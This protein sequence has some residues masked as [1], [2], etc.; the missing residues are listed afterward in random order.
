MKCVEVL[1]QS[2]RGLSTVRGLQGQ[3]QR[4][5]L[6]QAL[7]AQRPGNRTVARSRTSAAD[8]Q[9]LDD[10]VVT[11]D[12]LARH[13]DQV[14]ILDVRG[15][16]STELVQPGVE[17]STYTADYDA[18]LEGHIPVRGSAVFVCVGLNVNTLLLPS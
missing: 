9:A 8:Y 17:Q 2:Q 6:A 5:S 14:S 13:L 15:H 12:W 7:V 3:Q 11:T 16:V 18:Y 1:M 10:P 4:N